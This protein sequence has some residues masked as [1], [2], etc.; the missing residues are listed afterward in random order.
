MSS[1]NN[2]ANREDAD[3]SGAHSLQPRKP[4]VSL[5]RF[6]VTCKSSQNVRAPVYANGRQQ[7]PVRVLIEARDEDGVVVPVDESSLKLE[8]VDYD[9]PHVAPNGIHVRSF[10]W[11]HFVYHW[12]IQRSELGH[13]ADSAS[14]HAGDIETADDKRPEAS[15]QVI[16]R[17]VS[18]TRVSVVK[19]A[20]KVTSPGGTVF[21]SNNPDPSQGK[22]DSYIII[23]GREPKAIHW[24]SF[25]ISEPKQVVNNNDWN[26]MMYYVYFK[27][28]SYKVVSSIHYQPQ[29]RWAYFRFY[30]FHDKGVEHAAFPVLMTQESH[31]YKSCTSRNHYTTF[32][33]NDRPGQANVAR[34]WDK[35]GGAG[36]C[37]GGQV[38]N[39]LMGYI[40]QY[41]NESK[42]TLKVSSS[43]SNG[44][45]SAIELDDP[46]NVDDLASPVESNKS[47][48]ERM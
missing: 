16:S 5:S 25:A 33:I 3:V 37:Y 44:F 42:V 9:T 36:Y 34:V 47:G 39:G 40:D 2:E 31:V 1:E 10:E 35:R 4:W 26:V 41:G 38:V 30:G 19:L 29:D 17:W 11:T 20:A 45:G 24:E 48:E 46:G 7:V 18:Y 8:L 27:D 15:L 43:G 13:D 32:P 14:G 6:E 23:E 21:I 28:P 12:T 22:F